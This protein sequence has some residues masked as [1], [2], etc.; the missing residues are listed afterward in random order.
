MPGS[1]LDSNIL[2]YLAT[3]DNL[4]IARS[5]ELLREDCIVSVQVL[6]EIANVLRRKRGMPWQRVR[7]FLMT[8]EGL[9]TVMPLDIDC[10]AI[11]MNVAERY[12][13]AIYDSMIIAAAL[14][15][16]CD[17]LYTEDMRHGQTIDGLL[18]IVNPYI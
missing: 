3:E 13:F 4:K 11:G 18:K 7:D 8:V 10:H 5:A 1:F 6:N 2:I 17:V 15:A 14:Q 9:A 16:R 12:G